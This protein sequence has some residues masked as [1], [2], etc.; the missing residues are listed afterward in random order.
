[1]S[2]TLTDRQW[3]NIHPFHSFASTGGIENSQFELKQLILGAKSH[4]SLYDQCRI[5]KIQGLKRHLQNRSIRDWRKLQHVC[6][7][8]QVGRILRYGV[9]RLVFCLRRFANFDSLSI[10][11][12]IAHTLRR[13][14]QG[15]LR[16]IA[17]GFCEDARD[18]G[19][20]KTLTAGFQLW[21][22]LVRYHDMRRCIPTF[23]YPYLRS[24]RL[25]PAM[26]WFAV[27]GS[28]AGEYWQERQDTK[29]ARIH[30]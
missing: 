30:S 4:L 27:I 21:K 15:S 1:M 7:T 6:F 8:N 23:L 5:P 14:G 3:T 18:I 11:S 19:N 22:D 26:H 24:P 28:E 16:Y 13:R 25:I 17:E 2:I 29:H 10:H 20:L 9:L 12:Y